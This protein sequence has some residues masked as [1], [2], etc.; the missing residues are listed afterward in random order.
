MRL[1]TELLL[2]AGGL[3]LLAA[4]A[5]A[6]PIGGLVVTP[7][8]GQ[9]ASSIRMHTSTGCPAEADAY[10]ASLR[11]KGMPAA[12]QVVVANTDVGL[13]HTS[14]F[15]VFLAQ[16]LKDFA[17]DNGTTLSGTYDV[18]LYCIDSFSQQSKG[19]FTA[20]LKFD[21]PV[22]YAALGAA[23]GPNRA[24]DTPSSAPPP[25]SAKPSTPAAPPRTSAG[26][27]PVPL[28]GTGS[29]GEPP[30]SAPAAEA[31]AAKADSPTTL[32]GAFALVAGV[33]LVVA[34]VALAAWVVR[35]R[36]RGIQ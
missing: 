28:P 5:Q 9:D 2:V 14:G 12:G 24:P 16:T 13:S 4:P 30:A 1:R 29:S 25:S 33:G 21:G 34:T 31:V 27:T 18:T 6:A 32:V 7:G 23:K 8:E 22:K 26:S 15:D 11:G 3:V 10:Y 17:E 35:R 19:E 20:E 36:A